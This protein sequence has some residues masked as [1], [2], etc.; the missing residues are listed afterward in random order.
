[1]G[2][3][4]GKNIKVS[5]FGESHGEAIG[6]VLD[7]VPSGVTLNL[8]NIRAMMKR[9]APGGQ[10]Y[11]TARVEKDEFEIQSGL[12]DGVTTGAP[13]CGI[14]RNT[15][16]NSKDYS[17]LYVK[18]RP[19]HADYTANLRYKGFQDVRGGGHF[20]G[21]L[22]API[23]LAGAICKEIL[24][25]YNVDVAAKIVKIGGSTDSEEW[26]GIIEQAKADLDSVGGV[27]EC[28]IDGMEGGIGNPMFDN[29]ESVISS[30]L[31]AIPAVK[32]VEFGAGFQV[33][34]MR[35][36]QANDAFY[37]DGDSVKTKTN[38]CGGIL[39]GITNGMPIVVRT[40]FKPTPSIYQEQDTVS[41]KD[42]KDTKLSIV[43]RHD[44]CV[45]VRAVPVIE[46]ACS[47]AALELIMSKGS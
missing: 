14:I 30:F 40:A 32:G 12:L 4:W 38:N 37:M 21:R 25:G 7:G 8:D 16:Q 46:A 13:I 6:M 39:G 11:S 42:K 9:R 34:D 45:V 3:M 28:T 27:V 18:P 23:T 33:S 35:G 36:S 29:V 10:A 19:G 43:G 41:L 17:E 22:T 26:E 2:S 20:S 15:N 1:M 47:I 5:I 24:R 44:P 31:F